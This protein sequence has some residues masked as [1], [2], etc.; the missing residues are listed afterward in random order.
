MDLT[1]LEKASRE[2]AA[3]RGAEVSFP[4]HLRRMMQVVRTLVACDTINI[5]TI[6]LE[7]EEGF[8]LDL[9][10]FLMPKERREHLPKFKHQHPMLEYSRKHG[11][12]PPL[13]FSDFLSRRQFEETALYREC[14]RGFT[15]SMLTF[16]IDAPPG[17]NISI[18]LSRESREFSENDSRLLAV[19]QPLISVT[20][21]RLLLESALGGCL[22]QDQSVGVLMGS[23][24]YLISLDPRARSLLLKHFPGQSL[25][26]VPGLI[27]QTINR[28]GANR[29]PF[30]MQSDEQQLCGAFESQGSEWLLKIWEENRAFPHDKLSA[31]SLTKRQIEVLFWVE[32]GK[33][34]AEVALILGISSRTVQK[35]LEHIYR[36]IGVENR[37]AAIVFCRNIRQEKRIE[38]AA[39]ATP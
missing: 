39:K 14:Y 7:T 1:L 12:N 35:H 17:L 9:D 15:H 26:K 11:V 24:R 36:I 2:I 20:Y 30:I 8:H 19:L 33:A 10:G 4:D 27:L 37:L 22:Q 32:Q 3:I 13:R 25:H 34:N 18:V 6:D 5:G 29:R 23:G 31:L 38:S 21:H 28:Q 16:G